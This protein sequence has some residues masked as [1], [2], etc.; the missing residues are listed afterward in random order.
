MLSSSAVGDV[1]EIYLGTITFHMESNYFINYI[2]PS[3]L[4]I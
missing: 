2:A 3:E 1:I 4:F